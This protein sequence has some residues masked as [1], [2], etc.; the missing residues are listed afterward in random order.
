M[1][2]LKL[3]AKLL[4]VIISL[5]VIIEIVTIVILNGQVKQLLIDEKIETDIKMINHM[6]NQEY[7][8][9]WNI[10]DNQLYKGESLINGN[11][12]LVDSVKEL[13]GDSI[14]IFLHDVRVATTLFKEGD[15]REI[16]TKA[17]SEVVKTVLEE[18]NKYSGEVDVEG[19]EYIAEY[20][21]IKNEKGDN[22]GILV[23]AIEQEEVGAI[24]SSFIKRQMLFITIVILLSIVVI[25]FFVNRIVKNVNSVVSVI[26]KAEKGDL[27]S[28][29]VNNNLTKC[30]E[31]MDCDKKECVAYKSEDLRCWQ[32]AGTHCNG[33]IQGEF[34]TKIEDCEQ[35]MVYKKAGGDEI[36]QM[37]MSFNNM[38]TVI[39]KMIKNI[40]DVC[41]QVSSSSQQLAASSEESGASANE[42]ATVIQDMA[43]STEKQNNLMAQTNGL[44][45]A[46]IDK[47]VGISDSTKMMLAIS[48]KVSDTAKDGEEIV[49]NAITQMNVINNSSNEARDII[50]QLESKS[51]EI[52][53]IVSLI[54][55]ISDQTNMLALNAAIEAARAGEHG[56]GF[57]VV[58][59]EVRKLAEE[60]NVATS[61][62]AE[63]INVIQE[64]VK[65]AVL[66]INNS[67]K[68]IITGKERI[69]ETE[70]SFKKITNSIEEVLTIINEVSKSVRST[71]EDGI[72]VRE[73]SSNISNLISEAT[74]GAQ[75]VSATTEEQSATA[76]EI[77]ASA[78]ELSRIALELLN[79]V[80][81]FR[82]E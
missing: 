23:L 41:G 65:S 30:W 28:L 50:I 47:L 8:G 81:I 2:N 68:E 9:Y 64:R 66:S 42:V 78:D 32:M 57:A 6:I 51:N 20:I 61:N 60:T 21:P 55:N 3:R 33:E 70:E 62:I 16:G 10:K 27:T 43:H 38:I 17:G 80:K 13:T 77:A 52:S 79:N 71:S 59:D 53:D 29:A 58:A 48:D 74:Q 7:E 25:V 5:F 40:M 82:V 34:S 46:L 75:Q 39:R 54:S 19:D 69:M 12:D 18:G 73:A 63:L 15:T 22:I 1:F 31:V 49:G 36:K 67:S 35:C 56:K 26:K 14:S 24:T 45:Q 37:I 76:E 72:K 44:I 4:L 11:N